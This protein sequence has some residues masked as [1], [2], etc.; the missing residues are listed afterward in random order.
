M[1]AQDMIA[2][3]KH[4]TDTRPGSSSRIYAVSNSNKFQIDKT[5]AFIPT[6]VA[7]FETAFPSMECMNRARDDVVQMR[8]E[9]CGC[10]SEI[11]GE[12]CIPTDTVLILSPI[13]L[14]CK[15]DFKLNKSFMYVSKWRIASASATASA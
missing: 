8:I 14:E 12:A 6:C 9:L 7:Y 5:P 10:A 13:A 15:H 1:W 4:I 2:S 11:V 3:I